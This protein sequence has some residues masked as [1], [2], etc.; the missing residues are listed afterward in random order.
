M[1]NHLGADN[2]RSDRAKWY[3][4]DAFKTLIN[5]IDLYERESRI[6]TSEL[7]LDKIMQVRT[8][9]NFDL[10][11]RS[12]F[13]EGGVGIF[14]DRECFRL[15]RLATLASVLR[16]ASS[17][18]EA[19][20]SRDTLDR[21]FKYLKE[22]PVPVALDRDGT[23]PTSYCPTNLLQD[24]TLL[25]ISTVLRARRETDIFQS[26]L[27][28]DGGD[29]KVFRRWFHMHEGTSSCGKIGFPAYQVSSCPDGSLEVFFQYPTKVVLDKS[30][31]DI[32]KKGGFML[33]V[34]FPFGLLSWFDAYVEQYG[35]FRDQLNK[36]ATVRLD[37]LNRRQ[38]QYKSNKEATQGYLHVVHFLLPLFSR[39]RDKFGDDL[40][41]VSDRYL[42][43]QWEEQLLTLPISYSD[44]CHYLRPRW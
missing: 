3:D 38:L 2:L 10:K 44:G 8:V 5:H 39:I 30:F 40:I 20:R 26:H 34:R 11:N 14:G 32:A 4:I 9:R 41:C 22:V 33:A 7:V 18:S 17:S 28:L 21:V 24:S 31:Q 27:D 42:V 19:F 37:H 25:R 16:Q 35:F 36:Y 29:S 1:P 6:H 12:L 13:R 23:R 15:K 43:Y